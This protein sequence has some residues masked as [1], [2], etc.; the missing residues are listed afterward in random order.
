MAE[1]ADYAREIDGVWTLLDGAFQIDG[2]LFAHN[3]LD[4]SSPEER[5][6]WKIK[7]VLPPD[8]APV[9]NI[10]APG[11]PQIIDHDGSPKY[12]IVSAPAPPPGPVP[13]PDAVDMRQARLKLLSEPH[14]DGTR[15]D[16]VNAYV[17]TQGQA[18]SIEWEYARELRRDHPLVGIIG[19]FFGL[20]SAALDDWFRE[21]A[22]I[23]PTLAT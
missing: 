21:A 8:S 10:V 5:T 3:W 15:L 12:F 1:T 4:L 2:S 7:Q 20:D 9:G 16:A 18:V 11:P 6:F 22:E 17:S 23:G 14:D 13:V 19:L